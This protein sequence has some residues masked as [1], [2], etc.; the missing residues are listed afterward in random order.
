MKSIATAVRKIRTALE[1]H[2]LIMLHDAELPSVTTLVVGEPIR[3]SWWAHPEGSVVFHALEAIDSEIVTA[4]LVA[5]K[6]TLIAPSLW[7]SLVA[8]GASR[9]PWQ[10]AGLSATAK[11]VLGRIDT[12]KRVRS[13]DLE[14]SVR[15]AAGEL[16]ERLLASVREVHGESGAH[17]RELASWDTF[18]ADHGILREGLTAKQAKATIESAI[19]TWPAKAKLPWAGSASGAGRDARGGRARSSSVRDRGR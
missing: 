3:G 12:G 8:I 1:R 15:K 4:K 18:A 19:A 5:K 16:D 11:T 7:P 14:P 10:T 13:I 17:H 2:G 9:E 6:V